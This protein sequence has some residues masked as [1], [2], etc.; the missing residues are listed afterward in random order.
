MAKLDSILKSSGNSFF[1]VIANWTSIAGNS[2][3]EIMKPVR[4]SKKVLFVAVPN[5]MVLK[6]VKRFQSSILEKVQSVTGKTSV[7]EIKFFSDPSKFKDIERKPK[8][9]TDPSILN[10]IDVERRYSELVQMGIDPAL[11]RT[12]AEIDLILKDKKRINDF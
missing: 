11:A 6:T 8:K 5:S 7:K 1:K 3:R 2:N 9:K 4:I 10:K 12:M